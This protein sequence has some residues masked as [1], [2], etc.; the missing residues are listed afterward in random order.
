MKYTITRALSELTALKDRHQKELTK[1]N[2]IA[3]KQGAKI[4]K[5]N[6]S[7]DEKS[8]IEQASQS[9]QSV[10]DIER[11]ILEI[12]NKIDESN[13]TTKVKIGDTEMTV[14]EV[15]NMKRL[16][17]LKQNRLYF[18][19]SMKQRAQMDFDAGNEENRRRIEKMSQ[20]QMSGS[21]SSKAGDAEK[22]IV[23][24]VEKIYKMDFIDPVNLSDEIE[25]LENEIA[26]FNNNVDYVLSESNSTTYIEVE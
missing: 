17:E 19:K 22:E 20:D 13:F 5:P 15:L 24:S 4:R 8:F 21:G 16:I 26:E 18:L 23:E 12:K 10:L 7:Y 25:K 2:L 11:R 9:Y 6:S 1:M 14:Q 3:V